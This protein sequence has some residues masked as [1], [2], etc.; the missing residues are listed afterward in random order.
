MA[1]KKQDTV[2]CQICGG[3]KRLSEVRPAELI[4][5]PLVEVIRKT[6]PNWSS[7]GFICLSDLNRF[8]AEYIEDILAKDKGELSVLEEQVVDSLKEQELLSENINLEFDRKLTFGERLA[9]KVADYAG[10]WR[11]ISIFFSCSSCGLP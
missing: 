1:R 8:R 2:T 10:S 6:Y 7:D 9:D 11:F 3:K 5:E 4:R